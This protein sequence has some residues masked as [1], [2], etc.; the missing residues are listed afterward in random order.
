M[1]EM[2][3]IILL[4][5]III[6]LAAGF[7]KQSFNDNGKS[8]SEILNDTGYQSS[9]TVHAKIIERKKIRGHGGFAVPTVEEYPWILFETD[10]GDQ[11]G[12]Q[13]EDR[14]YHKV[15]VGQTGT[16]CY[17]EQRVD[18]FELDDTAEN[19]SKMFL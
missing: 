2:V 3:I 7:V 6:V 13:V 14:L 11:L 1:L 10:D 17:N 18:Y 9:V 19:M 15:Y 5:A 16:L 12:F 4:I 8:L